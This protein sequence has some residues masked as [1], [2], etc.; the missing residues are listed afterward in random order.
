M[1]SSLGSLGTAGQG[2]NNWQRARELIPSWDRLGQE[3]EGEIT[4]EIMGGGGG[5]EFF[6]GTAWDRWAREK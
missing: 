6:P 4:G 1:N 3:G 2:R 5:S